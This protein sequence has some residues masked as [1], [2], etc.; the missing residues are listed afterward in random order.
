MYD[1]PGPRTRRRIQLGT[2]AVL[3]VLATL[4]VLVAT[5][6]AA[7][8]QFD[9]AK[10]GPLI[11]P[12]HEQFGQVWDFLGEG[13]IATLQAAAI[14]I[15]LSLLLGT[16][17]AVTR[18]SAAAWYRWAVV[19]CIE[20][21]RGV[22]VVMSVF[23]AARVLPELGLDL[24][25]MWFLVIGLTLYNSVVIAE[26]IRAGI[27]AL[28]KGQTEA[29]YAIGLTR[30]AALRLILLPQAFRITLPALIGQLVVVLKD[31]SLGFI[32]SYEELLRRGQIAVQ[33]LENPLQ[34]FFVIGTI[35]I[36]VNFSL[37]KLA[38]ALE[39]RMSR[40]GQRSSTG[41]AAPG[42]ETAAETEAP[43]ALASR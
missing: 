41:P 7:Q 34:T 6:L 38:E 5:R 32:I 19:G 4:L 28:P 17:L 35:F 11:D 21:F 2:G 22:P 26:V 18:F 29:A 14:A 13:L 33:T 43:S 36:L 9:E 16:A 42:E 3:L 10:W 31:T 27:Q 37:S 12:T 39:R 25:V 15:V 23:F 8:G 40:S 20:F 30:G 1:A 24:P